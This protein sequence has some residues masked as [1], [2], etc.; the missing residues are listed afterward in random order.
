MAAAPARGAAADPSTWHFPAPPRRLV[1]IG[2]VHGDAAALRRALDAAG[3]LSA[4]GGWAGGDAVL[5]QVG[6]VLDRWSEERE[7]LSMLFRLQDEAP[8]SGGAVHLLMVRGAGTAGYVCLCVVVCCTGEDVLVAAAAGGE[9][10]LESGLWG[11]CFQGCWRF[12]AASKGG[13]GH[14]GRLVGLGLRR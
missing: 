5:V 12:G 10:T 11:D 8:A 3:L 13:S 14:P 9:W 2:D 1:A 6:D 4:T 7:A